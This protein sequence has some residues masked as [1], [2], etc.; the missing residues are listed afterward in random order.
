MEIKSSRKVIA[1]ALLCAQ[2]KYWKY[3]DIELGVKDTVVLIQ[4]ICLQET[5]CKNGLLGR[6]QNVVKLSVLLLFWN[7]PNYWLQK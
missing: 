6:C 7:L 1:S 5:K 2:N 3:S 4:C